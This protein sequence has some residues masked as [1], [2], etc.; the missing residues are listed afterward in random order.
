LKYALLGVALILCASGPALAQAPSEEPSAK[1]EASLSGTVSDEDGLGLGGVQVK[2]FV[3]GSLKGSGI[4]GGNGGY[5]VTF[6]YDE[7]GD[8]SIIAW[9]VP[10]AGYVPE[11]AVLRESTAAKKLELWSPCLPRIDIGPTISYNPTIYTEE[12]K[13]E[14]LGQSDCIEAK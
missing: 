9:W 12:K 13:F 3:G 4:S 2:V 5:E 8:E 1:S 7:L 14:Q 10:Q 6:R 11:I